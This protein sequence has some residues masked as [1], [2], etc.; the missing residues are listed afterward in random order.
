MIGTRS[1]SSNAGPP[2]IHRLTSGLAAQRGRHQ[3]G[4]EFPFRG[5]FPTKPKPSLPEHAL[6]DRDERLGKHQAGTEAQ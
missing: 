6:H 5:G 4:V 2:L 3:N 1:R